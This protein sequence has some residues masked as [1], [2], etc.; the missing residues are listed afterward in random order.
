[1]NA[2]INAAS[3]FEP[4]VTPAAAGAVLDFPGFGH[5][6]IRKIASEETGGAFAVAEIVA[7]PGGGVPLHI[8]DREEE[9][10]Y[11]LS[12]RFSFQVGDDTLEA[13]P[14]DT[15][16]GPRRI[17]H[18]WRCISPSEGRMIAL[19]SPGDFEHFLIGLTELPPPSDPTAQATM[20][21]LCD[22]FG[23]QFG[24]GKA[25]PNAAPPPFVPAHIPAGGGLFFDFGDHRG[26]GKISSAQNGGA[27]LLAESEADPGGG[28]PP[29]IHTQEDETF[30]ILSG[31]FA[32]M[33][34]GEM[35]EAK[36]GD[37]IFAPRN[38]AHAWHCLGETPGR[39]FAIITPGANFEAFATEMATRG[40][41]PETAMADP[42]VAVEFRKTSERYGIQMLPAIK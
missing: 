4:V 33:V 30:Y 1:M 37:T 42:Q 12:G 40:L 19:F 3:P 28:V 16:F 6:I 35:I 39:L 23:I 18:S 29:H 21:A 5:H 15:V 2:V 27:F 7:M 8:H 17:A 24:A 34:G 31:R 14:G 22:N 32:L 38:R 25:V 9:T 20:A 10:F 26:W 11:I 13:G 41:S 36:P